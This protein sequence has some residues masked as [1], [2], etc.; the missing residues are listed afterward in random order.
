[1]HVI[2]RCLLIVKTE[3]NGGK[4]P[5]SLLLRL[6]IVEGLVVRKRL[7]LSKDVHSRCHIAVDQAHEFEIIGGGK[8]YG[9]G[10]PFFQTACGNAC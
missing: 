3:I 9:K 10:L 5:F 7:R 8:S 4:Q 6:L 1:M 2:F